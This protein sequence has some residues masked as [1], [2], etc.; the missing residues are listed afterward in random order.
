[1]PDSLWVFEYDTPFNLIGS[2]I[3]FLCPHFIDEEKLQ[4]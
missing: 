3:C 2:I 1:M 4:E